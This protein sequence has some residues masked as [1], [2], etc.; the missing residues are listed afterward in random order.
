MGV[1]DCGLFIGVGMNYILLN[2]VFF[3]IRVSV[4]W[5]GRGFFLPL[6]GKKSDDSYAAF[7]GAR[8]HRGVGPQRFRHF[9]LSSSGLIGRVESCSS[10]SRTLMVRD[11]MS[12]SMMSPSTIFPMLPPAAASGEMWPMLSPDVPPEKRP[13]VISAQ[14]FPRCRLLM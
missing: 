5:A 8:N 1:S 2:E 12:I 9:A 14:A 3:R 4:W 11:G 7:V 10:V 13:S 6:R